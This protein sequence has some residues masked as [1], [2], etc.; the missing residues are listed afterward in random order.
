MHE[1]RKQVLGEF[2]RMQKEFDL[3]FE[4]LSGGARLV[5]TNR[6]VWSPPADV[7]ATAQYIVVKIEIAGLRKED[8]QITFDHGILTVSGVRSDP[9]EKVAYQ[10]LEIAYGE[11]MTQVH[12]PWLVDD[13][14][15]EAEYFQGF[16]FI[17]LPRRSLEH[18]RITV[19]YSEE[20]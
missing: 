17:K 6:R 14:Q 5:G 11:F 18:T 16:L 3:F 1:N 15:I 9:S 19:K 13:D 20:T 4:N 10:R 8:F 2:D 7:Y 12:V